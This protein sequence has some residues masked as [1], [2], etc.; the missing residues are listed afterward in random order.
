MPLDQV[1][2][3]PGINSMASRSLNAGGYSDGSLVRFRAG[4][5]EKMGGWR[6]FFTDLLIGRCR[7]IHAFTELAGDKLLGFGTHNHVYVSRGGALVD[8]TP[9]DTSLTTGLPVT[10]T[11]TLL[12]TVGTVLTI[13]TSAPHGRA[14][15]DYVTLDTIT[16][17]TRTPTVATC[18]GV[19][20][21][22]DFLVTSVPSSTTL[23]VTLATAAA[24]A[25][26]ATG[27]TLTP[28]M[29]AGQQDNIA[30]L[31]WGAGGWGVAGWGSPASVG[32]N[33][34]PIRIVSLDNWG[35]DMLIGPSQER[36]YSWSPDSTGA[37]TNRA[38]PIVNTT[39]AQGPPL[40]NG[41]LLVG[42]PERHVILLGTSSLNL[43]TGFDP[44]LIRWSHAEDNTQ[45]LASSTN[46]AGSFRLQG[47]S[48]IMGGY[49]GNGQ[50]LIWTDTMLHSMRFI[51]L[52]YVYS[53]NKIGEH[54]GLIS[55]KAFAESNGTVY[56]MGAKAFWRF[57]GGSPELVPCSML[58]EVFGRLNQAQRNKIIC[59]TDTGYNEV[60]WY[61]PADGASENSRYVTYNTVEGVW[62]GGALARSAWI[63]TELF[64]QPI[65][66]TSGG[67]VY[68]HNTGFDADGAAMGDFIQ[69]GYWD[70]GAG[71]QIMFASKIIPDFIGT[72]IGALQGT[73]QVTFLIQEYPHGR[74]TTKGPYPI[75]AGTLQRSFRARGR[76]MALRIESVGTGGNWRLGKLRANYQTDGMR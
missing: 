15:G 17:T 46:S 53:I 75:T 26:N 16:G 64:D 14:A 21:T 59:G 44:M 13:T 28:F 30:G 67:Q 40:R 69:S 43:T 23:T 60:T 70:M 24:T 55:Q 66:T 48:T 4:L 9:V 54:C 27:Y 1:S 45:Y 76:Q 68:Q 25:T 49:N 3:R 12:S 58:A 32:A 5:P 73:L 35:Q 62:Y 72:D 42:S 56:W 47:G 22:G 38:V 36:I 50:T 8:V 74:V 19:A 61:Y 18:G 6:K 10:Y 34:L 71:E 20:L 57:Q 41:M 37:V 39:P 11:T 29:P 51:G 2:L 52:P 65:A 7:S 33:T 31:G 63:D